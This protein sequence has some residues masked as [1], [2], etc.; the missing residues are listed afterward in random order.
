MVQIDTLTAGSMIVSGPV[1]STVI[2][3]GQLATGDEDKFPSKAHEHL[4]YFSTKVN[5]N[6]IKVCRGW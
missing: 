6:P 5:M 1:T 4:A 2:L 3:L